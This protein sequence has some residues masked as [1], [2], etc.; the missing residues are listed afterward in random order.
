MRQRS[1]QS[2][3]LILTAAWLLSA[4]PQ[5]SVLNAQLSRQVAQNADENVPL[6][7]DGKMDE[8]PFF[9][10]R[11]HSAI[12]YDNSPRDVAGNLARK[13]ADGTVRLRFEK[14]NGYL[15]SV[16]EALQIPSESQ[17]LIFS[18]TSLQSHYISPSNPRALFYTDDVSVGFI[19]NAPLLEISA[20]DPKQGVIF[21]ALEQREAERPNIAR[22]DSCLSCHESRSTMDVPGMLVR[23]MAVGDGGQTMPQ[24]GNYVSD[25]RS[26]FIER[27]GGWFITGS[28]GS[29][30]HMGNVM[31][32]ANGTLA[33]GVEAPKIVP[34]LNGKFD[35]A[36]Y[37]ST[38]SDV[39]AVMVL[40]H[41]VMMTNLLTRVGWETRVAL[42]QLAKKASEK[43]AVVRLID[44]DARELVDYLLFVD[45]PPLSGKFESTSGFA[46]KF[47][48]AG[49]RDNRGR[50]LRQLD[51]GK[52]LMRYPCSYMI[53][54]A[55][56]EELPGPTKDAIYARL[57]A[58]LSGKDKTPKYSKLSRTERDE[59]VSILLETRNALPEYFVRLEK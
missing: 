37:P 39:A 35:L 47:A 7:T 11:R 58:I 57:W 14:S 28:A 52:R 27:W 49:P 44:A 16:L 55:A 30:H 5:Q 1:F 38:Y 56:F 34:S 22:S 21:Y 31:L 32:A 20:L 6:P 15:L 9:S 40:D 24:F 13:V 46:A 23:S 26:P 42:D 36:G 41:Q 10:S 43:S 2:A 33:A 29:A 48:A 25:H 8:R 4:P 18:K 54:S 59:I 51:L 45:E 53:Y 3:F 12:G 50:S 17:S 19:R